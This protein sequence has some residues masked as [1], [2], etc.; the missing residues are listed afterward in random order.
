MKIEIKKWWSTEILFTFECENN[1]IALTLKAAIEA[2]A[3]LRGADLRGADLR[4]ANLCDADLCDANLHGADLRGADLRGANLRGANLRGA[5][6]PTGFN[7][8]RM[9]FGGWSV[10]IEAE[11][12]HIGCQT[13]PNADWLKW[14]P[15]DVA[16][17]SGG[18]KEY[19]ERW[20]D[21]IKAAIRATMAGVKAVAAEAEAVTQ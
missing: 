19:W 18:A 12:T 8:C 13:H 4:D 21:A 11:R 6:L 1:T 2:G 9:E 14:A 7:I 16:H 5:D 15:D 20:G 3:D 17:M 10:C